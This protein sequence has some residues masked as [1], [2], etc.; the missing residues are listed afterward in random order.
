[1]KY[2]HISDRLLDFSARIGN[3]VD[4]LP[5]TR[6]GKHV[7]GQLVR[8]GTSPAPNYDEGCAAESRADFIHKLSIALKELRESRSWI[9]L[10]IRRKMLT[11]K[12]ML[13][14]FDECEQLGNIL[15]ASILTAKRNNK[16]K[17]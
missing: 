9:K 2:E 3:V 10:I 6:M 11:E 1:M 8:C 13:G 12:Q 15:A 4:S 14:L 17:P 7:A 16:R 5:E